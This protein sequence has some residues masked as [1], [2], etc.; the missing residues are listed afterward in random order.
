MKKVIL[1]SITLA[2]V[3]IIAVA[4]VLPK[5]DKAPAQKTDAA[6]PKSFYELT[7]P[8]LNGT[9]TINFAAYKGKKIL[10]VNVAS[11]CGY[12]YQYEDL[13]KL[14]EKYADKLVLIGFPCNQFGGQEPGTPEEIGAF[15][16]KNYGVSFTLTEKIDVKGD[17]QHPVY[18]WL[19]HK[20]YNGKDD[21]TVGW[22]FNKFL[23][24][25]NGNFMAHF[26]SKTKP[27]DK[28]LVELIEK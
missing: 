8:A 28:E 23:L 21:Y 6:A 19:T 7:I 16:K 11:E 3:A 9:D 20:T 10:C 12:T 5:K 26:G 18:Q 4:F 2:V 15:C 1:L 22:N 14:H 25:E 24:D 27:F 13:Q 17:N